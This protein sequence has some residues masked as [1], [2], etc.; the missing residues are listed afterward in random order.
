MMLRLR[1][2]LAWLRYRLTGEES[3]AMFYFNASDGKDSGQ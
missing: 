1:Y 2:W 3:W